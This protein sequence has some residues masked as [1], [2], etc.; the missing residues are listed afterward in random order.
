MGTEDLLGQLQAYALTKRNPTIE[1]G[2]FLRTLPLEKQD[3][4]QVESGVKELAFKGAF[5]LQ[6]EDGRLLSVS[7]PDLP[8]LA[9]VEEYRRLVQDPA[10]PFPREETAPIPVPPSELVTMDVKGQLG[11]LF[12]EKQSDSPAIVK[13]IFPEGI[14]SLLVPRSCG[15]SE[16]VDAAVVRVSRYLQEM[17]NS[18]YAESKLSTL[19]RGSEVVARQALED[20]ALR[21]RKSVATILVPTE[22][23]FRFWNHLA[24]VLI[25]DTG[26]KSELTEI[27]KGVL[28]SA[29]IV[30]YTVF[31]Q[32]G[33]AQREQERAADKKAL[34]QQ[35]RRAPFVFGY[36]DMYQL[37]DDKGV[38][39]SSKHS[40]EFI[41]EFL[42]EYIQKK[43]DAR[44]P[45]LLR[46][47]HAPTS[48][49]YFVQ[50]DILVPVFLKKLT[51]AA[52]T[53]RIDYVKEWV[54][55]LR[56]DRD[57]P[58][59]KT[60]PLFRK[61]LEARVRDGFPVL[62]A[63]ANGPILNAV[64]QSTEMDEETRQEASRCFNARGMLRPMTALLGLTRVRLLR[65]ARSYL[66]FWQTTP[67]IRG[68]ARFL[69][70][71]FRGRREDAD[72]LAPFGALV[73]G[74]TADGRTADGRTSAASSKAAAGAPSSGTPA[75]GTPRALEDAPEPALPRGTRGDAGRAS[76]DRQS[77]QLYQRSIRA[78]ISAYVPPEKKVELVLA[79]LIEKWNPLLEPAPKQDL[80]KDVNALVQDF[81]RPIRR[82]FI[83]K[84][85]DLK[86]VRLLAEQL[87]ASKSLARIRKR[88]PLLRYLE[89]YMLR[90]LL[91]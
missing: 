37:R 54:D 52:D 38:T 7:I 10:R 6:A 13:L 39:Y 60:D 70:R 21:P 77:L 55:Q 8:L 43:D 15:R 59:T 69:R 83:L 82:D 45:Y 85:P 61:D 24:N 3:L 76:T 30:I 91:G 12:D 22:F 58:V 20:L 28:Q 40:R 51:D 33:V 25:Q 63:L 41:H 84:P 79:E 71:L 90:T 35:V 73:D 89:L 44:L 34:E 88:E 46:L 49:D 17:K 26:R 68:I 32:K 5:A 4:K 57:P 75:A 16:M 36:Q 42:S 27:D 48:R 14:P 87:S 19:L 23:S 62:A 78:L 29:Y 72:S 31:H 66:P 64:L 65:E 67:I 80:V 47:H 18:A 56:Q 1:L 81:V 86:R 11:E 74:R 9:L 2:Q 53:L 50:R